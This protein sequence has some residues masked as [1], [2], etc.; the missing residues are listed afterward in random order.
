M[1]DGSDDLESEDL[2]QLL[3]LL[4]D[5]VRKDV[6]DHMLQQDGFLI[7]VVLG[8]GRSA[9]VRWRDLQQ[10]TLKVAYVGNDSLTQSDI[11]SVVDKLGTGSFN[12]QD[13]AGISGTLYRVSAT[14]NPLGKVVILTMRAGRASRRLAGL[15]DDVIAANSS[16]LF[17]GPPGV[18]KT[19]L[20]RACAETLAESRSTVIIDPTGEIAGCGDASHPAV[21]RAWKDMAF[22]NSKLDRS[23]A[24]RL[25]MGRALENMGPQVLVVD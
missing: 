20:L 3:P 23:E 12:L 15:L 2:G 21:G 7:E 8:I 5:P 16:L 18:G 14:R 24:R 6:K 22:S 10:A 19:T 4:P 17:L 25:A 11:S 1:N 13:R 9:E